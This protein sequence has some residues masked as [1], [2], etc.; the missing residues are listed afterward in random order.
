[1]VYDR[2]AGVG[3][4]RRIGDFDADPDG[5]DLALT[6]EIKLPY[7]RTSPSFKIYSAT[8]PALALETYLKLSAE[9]DRQW[10]SEPCDGLLK[11]SA[12]WGL[13]STVSSGT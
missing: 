7:L 3:L 1:M 11:V 5:L 10:D 12:S 13:R 8:G 6:A 9:F 4:D 2:V